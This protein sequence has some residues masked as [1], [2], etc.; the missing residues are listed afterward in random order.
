MILISFSSIRN[1]IRQFLVTN[2]LH[3]PLRLPVSVWAFQFGI[4]CNSFSFSISWRKDTI[5]L[6]LA[7]TSGGNPLASSLSMNLRNPLCTTLLI[8]ISSAYWI[9]LCCV[10][11]HNTLCCNRIYKII[12]FLHCYDSTGLPHRLVAFSQ[13][14]NGYSADRSGFWNKLPIKSALS[15]EVSR[16]FAYG[17]TPKSFFNLAVMHSACCFIRSL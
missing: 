13:G 4:V 17:I 3:V 8:F 16:K 9:E 15:I 5:R 10:K 6:I 7:R 12:C 1:V 11:L 2:R 14:R